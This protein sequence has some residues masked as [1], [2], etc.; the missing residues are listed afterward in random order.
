MT[1]TPHPDG[2]PA[3]REHAQVLSDIATGWGDSANI[4]TVRPRKGWLCVEGVEERDEMTVARVLPEDPHLIRGG[5]ARGAGACHH[6]LPT[7]S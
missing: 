4:I 3:L 5:R 1:H 2:P 7:R 6:C